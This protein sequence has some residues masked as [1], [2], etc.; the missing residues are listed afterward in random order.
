MSLVGSG[1]F[2]VLCLFCCNGHAKG[3][4]DAVGGMPAGKC[5]V[6]ALNGRGERH[7]S[8]KFAVGAE[9]FAP[10]SE[11]LVSVGLVP[12]IPYYP[13]FGRIEDIMQGHGYLYNAKT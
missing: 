2:L 8:V 5:V 3:S 13:V 9:Q 12:Y 7:Q 6:F 4:R 10:P 1:F 11:N